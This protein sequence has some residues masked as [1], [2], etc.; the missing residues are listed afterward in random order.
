MRRAQR[1]TCEVAGETP[2][3]P[4]SGGL[5]GFWARRSKWGKAEI[6]IGA[7][8]TALVAI[9]LAVPALDDSANT[10]AQVAD[11]ETTSEEASEDTATEPDPTTEEAVEE[12]DDGGTGRMSRGEYAWFTVFLGWL[13]EE[14]DQL[15]TTLPKCAVRFQAFQLAAASE[16]VDQAYHGFGRRV[17]FVNV[18]VNDLRDDEDVAKQCLEALNAYQKRLNSFDAFVELLHRAGANLQAERFTRIRRQAT[19]QARAYRTARDAALLTCEP[20]Q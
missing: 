18:T 10:S 16:C 6:I 13:D 15:E 9:G 3:P 4:Q 12:G 17:G 2:T 5:R 7:V 1:R 19:G 20:Q 14:I 8:A 11:E